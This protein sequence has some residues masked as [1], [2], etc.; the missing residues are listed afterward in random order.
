MFNMII[1]PDEVFMKLKKYANDRGISIN[2]LLSDIILDWMNRNA[3]ISDSSNKSVS[4]TSI[5]SINSINKED[6]NEDKSVGDNTG[7]INGDKVFRFKI[8]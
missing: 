3:Y 2:N 7:E 1:I 6:N 5:N 4:E 8:K